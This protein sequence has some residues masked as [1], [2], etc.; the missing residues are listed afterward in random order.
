MPGSTRG[1]RRRDSSSVPSSTSS[2]NSNAKKKARPSNSATTQGDTIMGSVP[3]NVTG[4]TTGVGLVGSRLSPAPR[5]SSTS[6]QTTSPLPPTF[7]RLATPQAAVPDNQV[8]YTKV[9]ATPEVQSPPMLGATD[10]NESDA[11]SSKASNRTIMERSVVQEIAAGKFF[12]EVKFVVRDLDLQ[13]DEDRNSF[14]QYFYRECHVATVSVK[15]SKD[16]WAF[17]SKIITFTLSQTRNDRNTA[18]KNAFV[19]K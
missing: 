19:G 10:W 6:S 13:W 3:Q 18:M 2:T 11:T 4:A 16:W 8:G 5:A 12:S 14:C 15:E 17:A 1:R 7:P 9:V